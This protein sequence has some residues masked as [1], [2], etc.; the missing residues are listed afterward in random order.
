M[1]VIVIGAG[2]G[3]LTLAQA[4]LRAGIDTR[5]YDR[6]GS[7]DDTGGYRLHVDPVARAAL[8]RHL[9]PT[10][11]QAIW[12]SSVG[13]AAFRRFGYLD[14]R[15]RVLASNRTDP[16]Q[17][18]L[19]IGRRPLRRLL[20]HGLAERDVLR[21]GAEFRHAEI[22]RD[23]TATA[24]FTDGHAERADLLVGADGAHSRVARGLA[25]RELVR[26][27][28]AGGLAGRTPLTDSTRALL[29]DA[30]RDGPALAF[31]PDGFSVFLAPHAP[32]ATAG[33][34]A[35][36][37][38]DV[39]ADLEPD[40]LAWGI[41]AG[42][43][44]FPTDPSQLDTAGLRQLAKTMLRSWAP[45]LRE[46]VDAADPT[47]LGYFAFNAADPDAELTP[48]ASGPITALGDAV[49]AMP[50]T[51]GRG[52]STA[53]RDAGVLADRLTAV[54]EGRATA[55][56]AVHEF[57]REMARY[58]PDAIRVSLA[59]LRWQRHFHGP[60]AYQAI[61]V[62]LPIAQRLRRRTAERPHQPMP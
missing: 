53:I 44:L 23:G 56:L 9:P 32:A 17:E 8:A 21:L 1:R 11:Y 62:A 51:G 4:L 22:N 59:P 37:C 16:R 24:H 58:A 47:S 13:P 35:E 19:Q 38:L 27:V 20:A 49:H 33:I 41:N 30:L 45:T 3:G 46:L 15:M 7:L 26:P 48:W 28:G 40:Y 57:E 14:H 18:A 42:H 55:S 60:V 12:A 36:T 29:P 43:D 2:I 34:R 39:P 50:P 31:G 5:V 61:R 10:L 54:T 52:A 6:D 25:G